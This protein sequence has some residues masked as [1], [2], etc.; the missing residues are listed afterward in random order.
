[1]RPACAM[2]ATCLALAA[3]GCGEEP[4]EA[5]RASDAY[6][7]LTAAIRDGDYE[8]A[9]ERLTQKTRQDLRKA[10]KVQQT[11]ACDKTLERVIADV[12]TDEDAL[13]TVTPSDVRIDGPTSATVN[14]VR[15]EKS[16]GE[17]QVEG[18]LDFVRP[19]LS[20]RAPQR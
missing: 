11:G 2:L 20:G 12:G 4:T 8:E 19:L 1:M 13:A 9:C 10:G 15:L 6:N 18:D 17:W 3:A 7:A 5:A 14:D 16:G